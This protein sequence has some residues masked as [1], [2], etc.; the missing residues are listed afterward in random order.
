MGRFSKGVYRLLCLA[1]AVVVSVSATSLIGC[2]EDEAGTGDENGGEMTSGDVASLRIVGQ[3]GLAADPT[4]TGE[5]PKEVA[6]GTPVVVAILPL[7]KSGTPITAQDAL[8][9]VY[10]NVKW[11]S[12]DE[13]IAAISSAG[14]TGLGGAALIATKK[15]GKVTITATYKS[16]SAKV[17]ITVK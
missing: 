6:V 16:L 8:T 10:A 12:S 15:P 2:G 14:G 13:S 1:C 9:D 7:D 11:T 17:D 3:S 4:G 5:V